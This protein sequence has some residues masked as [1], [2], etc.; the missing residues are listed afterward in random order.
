MDPLHVHVGRETPI[1]LHVTDGK[2][3]LSAKAAKISKSFSEMSAGRPSLRAQESL[4]KPTR[5]TWNSPSH[6]LQIQTPNRLSIRTPDGGT[7][8]ALQ[9][10]ELSGTGGVKGNTTE[11]ILETQEGGLT[12]EQLIDAKNRIRALESE[13][14]RI[15]N[16]SAYLSCDWLLG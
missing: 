15:V 8:P 4:N 3:R 1:H 13:V 6:T 16:Y 2:K 12:Q 10:S 5:L 14:C 11:L 9:L 7:G